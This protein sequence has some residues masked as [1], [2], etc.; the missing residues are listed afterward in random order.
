MSTNQFQISSFTL[1][2]YK[3]S[4]PALVGTLLLFSACKSKKAIVTNPRP[5]KL[6]EQAFETLY[7]K[8]DSS[9]FTFDWMTAKADAEATMNGETNSFEI[10]LR[11]RNDSAIWLSLTATALNIEGVRVLITQDSI[12]LLDRMNKKYIISNFA[13]MSE[14]LHAEINFEML[15]NVI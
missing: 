8:M 7:D 6:K 3:Y 1:P 10:N 14:L 12:K 9:A 15:Q 5:V 11:I 2:L 13:E 4:I